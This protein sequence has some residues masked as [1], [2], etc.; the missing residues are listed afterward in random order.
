MVLCAQVLPLSSDVPMRS[1]RAPR[2]TSCCHVAMMFRRLPGLLVI[3]GSISSPVIFS[4]SARAPG[5]PAAK[6]LGPDSTRRSLTLCGPTEPTAGSGA[7]IPSSAIADPVAKNI[8]GLIAYLP[9]RQS[10]EE[11]ISYTVADRLDGSRRIGC[12]SDRELPG[13]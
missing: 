5:Q 3:A 13:T 12:A 9:D 7:A 8:L 6:G 2:P 4:S 1:D 10:P 11:A